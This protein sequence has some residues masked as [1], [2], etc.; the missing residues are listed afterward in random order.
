M[1]RAMLMPIFKQIKKASSEIE[2]ELEKALRWWLAILQEDIC[3]IR[4][5][6]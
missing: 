4:R 1:G 2:E 6:A 3:E 5:D